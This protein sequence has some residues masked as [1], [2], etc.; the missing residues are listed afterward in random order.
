MLRSKA[1]NKTKE[2]KNNNKPGNHSQN[3]LM[4]GK[5][6]FSM[7]EKSFGGLNNKIL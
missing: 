2:N 5:T 4:T 6:Q 1:H 3:F 7:F